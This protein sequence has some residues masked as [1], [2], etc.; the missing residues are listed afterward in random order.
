MVIVIAI[1]IIV[2]AIPKKKRKMR[3]T[4]KNLYTINTANIKLKE[5]QKQITKEACLVIKCRHHQ[6]W[7]T[8]ENVN[9]PKGTQRKGKLLASMH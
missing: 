1:A 2:A 4:K 8:L 3:K 6:A 5:N 7:I 9:C